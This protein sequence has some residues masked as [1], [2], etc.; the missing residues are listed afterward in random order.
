MY[1]RK[2]NSTTNMIKA[3]CDSS[4]T[5]ELLCK[6]G[7]RIGHMLYRVSKYVK[8]PTVMICYNCSSPSH[9]AANCKKDPRCSRCSLDHKR[10]DCKVSVE[11]NND[12]KC[13]N[14]DGK[15]PATYAGCTKYQ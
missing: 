6:N 9:L 10:E 4:E 8:K 1:S 2:L 15:H 5:A 12:M 14:F 11:N 13:P 3:V 7:L